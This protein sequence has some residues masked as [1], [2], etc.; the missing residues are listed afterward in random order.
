M[1]AIDII[2]L[3]IFT[4][5][6]WVGFRKGFITQ[7]GSVAAIIVAIVACRMFG[8]SLEASILGEYPDW[9]SGFS[10]YG[11]SIIANALIYVIV[12]YAVVIISKFLKAIT[13]AILLGP[14]DRIAGAIFSVGK[15]GLVVSLILNLYIVLFPDTSLLADSRLADGKA[16]EAVVG[17]APKVFD[18][19]NPFD[20]DF[21]QDAEPSTEG[22]STGSN[23]AIASTTTSTSSSGN[24][25]SF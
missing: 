6:A 7:L 5:A 24:N 20:N 8:A 14:L 2:L 15:Y 1:T 10:R 4:V 25:T 9:N 13:H 17:F 19:I 18:A 23:K 22:D 16:V 3:L 12:Y 21:K 11:V